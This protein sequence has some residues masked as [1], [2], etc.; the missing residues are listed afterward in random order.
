[1]SKILAVAPMINTA[2]HKPNKYWSS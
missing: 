2:I 1:M